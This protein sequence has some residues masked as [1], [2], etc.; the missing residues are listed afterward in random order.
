MFDFF[1]FS[2]E[3]PPIFRF[4]WLSLSGDI[5]S[6][7][8]GNCVSFCK[9]VFGKELSRQGPV[10]CIKDCPCISTTVFCLMR[11]QVHAYFFL[12]FYIATLSVS[13]LL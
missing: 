1:S 4:H 9:Y 2:L 5:Y 12:V 7:F 6:V 13:S 3:L 10:F 8:Q 11:L